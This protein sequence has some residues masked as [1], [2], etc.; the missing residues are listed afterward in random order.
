MPSEVMSAILEF[1]RTNPLPDHDDVTARR[2]AVEAA[3][4]GSLAVGTDAVELP[5]GD[6][7]ALWIRPAGN[8]TADR[9][10]VLYVHGGAF[11][12]GSPTAYRAFCS[13]LALLLDATVVVPDYR[14]APEHP[15][16]SAVDD[17]AS[18]YRAL[19]DTG[20]PASAVAL[21]GDSAGGGLVLSC[22][23]VARR[24]GLAQP[25]AAVG[26]SA[27]TD[28]T[29][30]ADSHDRCAATDPFIRTAML[31]RAAEHYLVDT[32]PRDPLASPAHAGPEDLSD[33]APILLQAAG[34]E[35][36]AD[37]SAILAK[38]IQAAGGDV[39]L[40]LCP[41]AFHVWPMAGPT[42]PESSD[43]LT[44]LAGFVRARWAAGRGG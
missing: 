20:L 11:E 40:E 3:L 39:T 14:L 21:L 33:L 7:P 22:L 25:A 19:L 35:V 18:A 27:W 31:R 13:S 1:G 36:L 4:V 32:D 37:D 15:F 5:L 44:S 41:E 17:V 16:P 10:V 42:V 34:N 12:V 30:E 2:E 28:L 24:A 9:P 8:E 6:R 26:I 43:A 23:I 38:R 29:L